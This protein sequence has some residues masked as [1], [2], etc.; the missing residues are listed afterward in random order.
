MEPRCHLDLV[1]VAG[2]RHRKA[3]VGA[4]TDSDGLSREAVP[5]YGP[6]GRLTLATEGRISRRRR[7]DGVQFLE[8]WWLLRPS[9]HRLAPVERPEGC[10]RGR[11]SGIA[12][13]SGREP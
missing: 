4:V 3:L 2:V 7:V 12:A 13:L 6:A 8:L 1:L 11:P 5:S 9:L 10:S